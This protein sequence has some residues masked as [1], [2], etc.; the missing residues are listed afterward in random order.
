M[1]FSFLG[2][3]LHMD[4]SYKNQSGFVSCFVLK[5]VKLEKPVFA[6]KD[7][8][9]EL[10]C[11]EAFIEPRFDEVW[12]KKAVILECTLK[13]AS[14]LKV[15]EK[16]KDTDDLTK[17][18]GGNLDFL[19][20]RLTGVLFEYITTELRIYGETAEFLSFE[21][22]SKDIALFASGLISEAGNF[23]VD[24]KIF[25]SAGLAGHFPEEIKGML[26]EEHEGWFSYSLKAESGKNGSFL[27]IDSDR[28]KLEFEEIETH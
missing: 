27:N 3:K 1:F 7:F 8:D 26:T 6:L 9:L 2:E 21:A 13:D 23:N 18:L 19:L 15:E 5:F 10:G 20:D 11:K 22:Y 25:F 24:M 28:F 4:I 14:F 16:L 12:T 17:I